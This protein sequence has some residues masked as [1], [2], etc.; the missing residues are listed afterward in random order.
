MQVIGHHIVWWF[1][2]LTLF[3]IFMRQ[4]NDFHRTMMNRRAFLFY[5][6]SAM[7]IG[8]N[9]LAYVLAV[10]HGFIIEAS[11]GYFIFPLLNIFIGV[12]FL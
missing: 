6:A 2:I 1:V 4:L 11:L 12:L 7:L 3:L 5:F 9:W 10:N 8:T